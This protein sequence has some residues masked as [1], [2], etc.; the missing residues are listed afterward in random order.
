M[1]LKKQHVDIETAIEKWLEDPF[2]EG[3][4]SELESKLEYNKESLAYFRK[5]RLDYTT[6]MDMESIMPNPFFFGKL[7]NRM[8]ENR[9]E[10]SHVQRVRWAVYA[11][12]ISASLVAGV[13]M[14]NKY[15]EGSI[16][17]DEDLIAEEILI[18]DYTLENTFLIDTE[19]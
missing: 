16:I 15:E 8:S 11:A 5:L 9:V 13:L 3:L 1:T 6:A 4:I 14:G 19:E 12:T 10:R 18:E 7:K 2:N 17:N